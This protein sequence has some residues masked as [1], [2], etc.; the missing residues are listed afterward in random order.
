MLRGK[1]L[2]ADRP[3]GHIM[4]T[5]SSS[6]PDESI[7]S[8]TAFA[9]GVF[10]SH[11]TQGNTNFNTLLSVCNSQFNINPVSGQRIFVVSGGRGCFSVC[12]RP[13]RWDLTIAGG[14]TGMATACGRCD[15]DL[16]EVPQ[17]NMDFRVL[18]GDPVALVVTHDFDELNGWISG[19]TLL[20][21]SISHCLLPEA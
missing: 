9:F 1:E 19:L 15:L 6:G 3:H 18:E 7:M 10:N 5:G 4:H 2:L 17:I 12:R 11:I 8:T 20:P 21:G 13:S 14:S 16:R